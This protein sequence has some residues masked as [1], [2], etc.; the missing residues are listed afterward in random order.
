M[1]LMGPM[2]RKAA[3]AA[4]RSKGDCGVAASSSTKHQAKP[5][6]TAKDSFSR[7]LFRAEFADLEQ[8]DG[9]WGLA[10]QLVGQVS[11]C[12]LKLFELLGVDAQTMLWSALSGQHSTWRS[13]LNINEHMPAVAL[14]LS[15][16]VFVQK[17]WLALLIGQPQH[18]W[19]AQQQLERQLLLLLPTVLL[20]CAVSSV[21]SGDS[22][23]VESSVELCVAA[24]DSSEYLPRTS[25]TTAQPP[26]D[27][28]RV[29]GVW[30]CEVLPL[31][32]QLTQQ[33]L[34]VA[35]TTPQPHP[36]DASP[37]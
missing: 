32:M 20:T 1:A 27:A 14:M 18:V 26:S 24:L 11:T 8:H 30:L 19:Q 22:A 13:W 35:A 17:Y 2:R 29:P 12:Q 31:V 5:L 7:T 6:K 25:P 16:R 4:A 3:A 10:R 28:V 33:R 15:R 21:K 36:T 9:G 34:Q 37:P 23:A